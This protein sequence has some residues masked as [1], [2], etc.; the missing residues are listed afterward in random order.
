LVKRILFIGEGVALAHVSRPL[1][2]AK[3]AHSE[4][5]EVVFATDE[6]NRWAL[7][8]APFELQPLD[9]ITPAQF[10]S[11]ISRGAPLFDYEALASYVEDDLALIERV[12]PDLVVGDLRLS[13]SVSARVARVPYVAIANAYWSPFLKREHWPVPPLPRL[14][15]VPLPVAN[16]LFRLIRP[17]AFGWHARPLDRVRRKYGLPSIGPRRAKNLHGCGLRRV[18]GRA[19]TVFLWPTPRRHTDSWDP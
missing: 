4:G 7:A 16:A 15:S 19:G 1:V 6:R 3:A 11:A 9:S 12:R 2:L 13:L 17:A 14:R 18:C 5:H 8:G 10:L